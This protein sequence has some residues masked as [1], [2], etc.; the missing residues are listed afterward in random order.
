MFSHTSVWV[1]LLRRA[2]CNCG[3]LPICTKAWALRTAM[4]VCVDPP[5]GSSIGAPLCPQFHCAYQLADWCLHHICTNYNN[6]CRKF[7]RDMKAMSPGKRLLQDLCVLLPHAKGARSLT[8]PQGVQKL[9]ETLGLDLS[10]R[11]EPRKRS[12]QLGTSGN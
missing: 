6:V 10:W 8:R 1:C 3:A 7:P 11:G 12:G 2:R 9:P 5:R 4:G